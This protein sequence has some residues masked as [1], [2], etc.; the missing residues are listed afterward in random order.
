LIGDLIVPMYAVAF[1][2]GVVLINLNLITYLNQR[3][4]E[5]RLFLILGFL[6]L[7]YLTLEWILVIVFPDEEA[8]FAFRLLMLGVNVCYYLFVFFWLLLLSELASY[9]FPQRFVFFLIAAYGTTMELLGGFFGDFRPETGSYAMDSEAAKVLM[10]LLNLCFAIWIIYLACR[11]LLTSLRYMEAGE[12]KRGV[13]LISGLLAL[14]EIWILIWDFSLVIGGNI[15]PR[16]STN[17]DPMVLIFIFYSIAVIWV[18]YKKDPLGI[19]TGSGSRPLEPVFTDQDLASKGLHC[20]LTER[21]LEVAAA[22]LNGLSN[23]EIGKCLF[24]SENTVKRHLNNIFR[25]TGTKS[26]Y[27]LLS[28]FW[29]KEG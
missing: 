13:I 4:E 16:E 19:C 25:K 23:P 10:V 21:E 17:I 20:G 26:R 2:L 5:N 6:I 15:D 9:K 3:I 28:L 14:Y 18:F 24:I 11:Y 8:V 22:V 12:K 29:G 27:E 1:V 7:F